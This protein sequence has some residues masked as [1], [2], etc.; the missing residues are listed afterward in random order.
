[1]PLA[2]TDAAD[3]VACLARAGVPILVADAA[4]GDVAEAVTGEG[5]AL[6][7]GNEGG[8]P[9]PELVRAARET[10]AIPMPGGAESLNAGVAG[11]ILLYALTQETR[12]V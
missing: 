12:R 3:A 10:L 2:T 8:G 4:G 9:R 11:A 6:V 7:V 1:M 5:W